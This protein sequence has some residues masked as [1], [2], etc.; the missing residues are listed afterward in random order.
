MA[1]VELGRSTTPEQ[2]EIFTRW[3]PGT[4]IAT[5]NPEAVPSAALELFEYRSSCFIDPETYKPLNFT[6]LYLITHKDGEH[7]FAAR[8]TNNLPEGLEQSAYIVDVGKNGEFL[9]YSE[10]RYVYDNPKTFFKEKPFQQWSGTEKGF[11]RRGL[12]TRRILVMN[13]LSQMLYGLPL[14]SSTGFVHDTSPEALRNQP[15]KLV[16]EKLV[17]EGDARKFKEGEQDRFV[18]TGRQQN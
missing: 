2:A 15:Q 9:G 8:Q 7:T 14:Y 10:L 16:W 1:Y 5:I 4:Q 17:R 13:A 6:A 18:F 3:F 11:T 12:S